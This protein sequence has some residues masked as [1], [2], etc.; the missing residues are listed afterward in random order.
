FNE[1]RPADKAKLDLYPE[2]HRMEIDAL[3]EWVHALGYGVY[4]SG[5]AAQHAAY[6]KDVVKLFAAPTCKNYLTEGQLIEADVRLFVTI[7]RHPS[8]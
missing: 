5:F 3:N 4:L 1:L 8:V 2:P 6:E 7:V